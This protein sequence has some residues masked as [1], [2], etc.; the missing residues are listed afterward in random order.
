M[1]SNPVLRNFLVTVVALL[2]LGAGLYMY[3]H[4]VGNKGAVSSQA[5]TTT[6]TLSDGTVLSGLPP[7]ATV[8]EVDE[9]VLKE[10][11]YTKPLV[12]SQPLD[13]NVQA[14]LKAQFESV[15]STLAKDNKNFDAWIRLGTLRK[16]A[17]DYQGAAE[18]WE[19]TLQLYPNNVVSYNNLADLYMNFIKN[20]PKAEA[21]FKAAIA[22]SPK[23]VDFYRSLF[24]LYRDIYKD[25]AKAEAIREQGLKNVPDSAE[26]QSL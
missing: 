12:I 1:N 6:Q 3:L 26:L 23:T 4:R 2:V 20:Y 19:Y 9:P 22:L 8:T 24:Y 25:P 15:K 5:S 16:I 11:D 21:D 17:G 7:G 13:A 18:V 14:A 10:P